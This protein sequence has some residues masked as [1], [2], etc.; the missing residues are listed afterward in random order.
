[1]IGV[2]TKPFFDSDSDDNV[3]LKH[4]DI[5]EFG[6]K[7]GHF[8]YKTSLKFSNGLFFEPIMQAKIDYAVV[9]NDNFEIVYENDPKFFMKIVPGIPKINTAEE[10]FNYKNFRKTVSNFEMICGKNAKH[11]LKEVLR[12]L[13]YLTER[14]MD[15]FDADYLRKILKE[16]AITLSEE[17]R[18]EYI[19]YLAFF[20]N[21]NIDMKSELF[22]SEFFRATDGGKSLKIEYFAFI[23]SLIES[24]QITLS[25]YY[26]KPEKQL[27]K[28]YGYDYDSLL[29]NGSTKLN[30]PNDILFIGANNEILNNV[31]PFNKIDY[32]HTLTDLMKITSNI[33]NNARIIAIVT[34]KEYNQYRQKG[35]NSGFKTIANVELQGAFN[36]TFENGRLLIMEKKEIP[37]ENYTSLFSTCPVLSGDVGPAA[38]DLHY[39]LKGAIPEQLSVLKSMKVT[40]SESEVKLVRI[41]D[42][43]EVIKGM[44]IT[45]SSAYGDDPE[46]IDVIYPITIG[47]KE[48]RK[49]YLETKKINVNRTKVTRKGDLII[50]TNNVYVLA[51][52]CDGEYL[53]SQHTAIIRPLKISTEKLADILNSPQFTDQ[54][55]NLIRSKSSKSVSKAEIEDMIL[56]IE[57]D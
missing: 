40:R 46:V 11:N 33:I 55:Y 56:E 7:I 25:G 21:V 57:E 18:E 39:L 24:K 10:F 26:G 19:S 52:I 49:E 43:C 28:L 30:Y 35:L 16:R 14:K 20:N 29:L 31:S 22:K 23:L 8:K 37:D 15:Y 41:R 5:D 47:R 13:G 44:S 1:M 6:R 34:N 17:E 42:I 54:F 48:L 45:S 4:I 9:S 27:M 32:P 50:A 51:A 12:I 3:Q 36:N 53:A 2:D 38:S